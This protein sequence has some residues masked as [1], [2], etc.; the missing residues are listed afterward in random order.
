MEYKE[1][2][3]YLKNWNCQKL[4]NKDLRKMDENK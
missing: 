1:L 3:K 2:G 4:E